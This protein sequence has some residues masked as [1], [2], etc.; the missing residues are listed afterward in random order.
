MSLSSS[1]SLSTGG[2]VC[3]RPEANMDY[4]EFLKSLQEN[5]RWDKEE[6]T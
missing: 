5:S 2:G 4:V 6:G 1:W 3:V